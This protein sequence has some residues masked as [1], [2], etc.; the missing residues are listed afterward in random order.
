MV[1]ANDVESYLDRIRTPA[2]TVIQTGQ[3]GAIILA[4]A[5]MVSRHPFTCKPQIN[6]NVSKVYRAFIVWNDTVY[7]IITPCLTFVATLGK[8]PKIVGE[9]RIMIIFPS[10]WDIVR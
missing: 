2:K 7:I 9:R 3:V 8:I 5:L 10:H 1:N 4:D 6:L